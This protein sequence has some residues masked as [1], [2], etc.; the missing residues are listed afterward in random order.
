MQILRIACVMLCT[1]ISCKGLNVQTVSTGKILND[2]IYINDVRIH[3]QAYTDIKDALASNI[4]FYLQK[5]SFKAA[6]Y[7][8]QSLHQ[9]NYRYTLVVDVFITSTGDILSPVQ[10]LLLYATIQDSS[11]HVATIQLSS[12][13]FDIRRSDDQ[14]KVAQTIAQKIDDMVQ[15]K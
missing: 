4:V 2:S 13:S 9:S 11:G 1:V 8:S 14:T 5:N 10:N 15:K 7:F 6:S 12:Q 3:H